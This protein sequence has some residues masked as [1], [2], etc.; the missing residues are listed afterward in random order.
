VRKVSQVDAEEAGIELQVVIM[1]RLGTAAKLAVHLA[2]VSQ[3][4]QLPQVSSMQVTMDFYAN[5]DDTMQDAIV[6]L[7]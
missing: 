1:E 7:T 6:R 2:Q 3:V 4:D 5:V